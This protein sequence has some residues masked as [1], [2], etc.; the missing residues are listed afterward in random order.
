MSTTVNRDPGKQDFAAGA[1]FAVAILL[2]TGALLGLLQGIAAVAEDDI[3]VVG[4][5]YSYKFST[6]TWGWIHIVVAVL[7]FAV[8]I[9][10]FT[11]ATWAR[12]SRRGL[13]AGDRRELP[14]AA[15][16]P[17]VVDPAHRTAPHRHLG[18]DHLEG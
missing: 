4:P 10:L 9:G 2:F 3:F 16:L 18:R 6:S 17:A 5:E 14:V 13:G 7:G 11:A 12:D 1:T 15:A 8:A